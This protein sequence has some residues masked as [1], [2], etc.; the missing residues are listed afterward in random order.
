MGFEDVLRAKQEFAR[1]FP[2]PG[3]AGT[4]ESTGMSAEAG[5]VNPSVTGEAGFV[6]TNPQGEAGFFAPHEMSYNASPAIGYSPPG[7]VEAGQRRPEDADPQAEQQYQ[8]DWY[9]DKTGRAS[10][11]IM[12]K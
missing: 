9:N 10:R 2:D 6:N 4:H 3:Q 8:R 1:K 11:G 12:N 5:F 7:Y